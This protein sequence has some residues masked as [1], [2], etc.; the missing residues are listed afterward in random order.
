MTGIIFHSNTAESGGAIHCVNSMVNVSVHHIYIVF[1]WNTAE[2]EG[3]AYFGSN[4]S[5]HLDNTVQFENNSAVHS[6]GAIHYQSGH[7][8]LTGKAIFMNNNVFNG[9]GGAIL[10]IAT[11]HGIFGDCSTF[12]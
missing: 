6:G 1:S 12:C 11:K 3:G 4:G 9:S 8:S 5:L 7:L 2:K 10:T